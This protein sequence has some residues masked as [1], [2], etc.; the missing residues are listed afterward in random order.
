MDVSDAHV[1]FFSHRFFSAL[2]QQKSAQATAAATGE[3]PESIARTLGWQAPPTDPGELADQW[4]AEIDRAGVSRAAMI[5]SIPGDEESVQA[6][7]ARYPHRFFGYFMVNPT[8]S[9]AEDRVRKALEAGNLHAVCLFPAMHRISI[10]DERI[11]RI[12][13]VV[14]LFPRTLVFVHCGVLTVGVRR[15]LGLPS[16]FD[17]RFSD[18]ID[19]H[20]VALV[21][22]GIHFVVPHFGAGYFREALMLCDLCPNVYLD[23][24]SSNSWMRYQPERLDL[25][26]VFRRALDVAGPRRLLFGSDSSFFPRGWHKQVFAEQSQAL[27]SLDISNAD[28]RCIFG[29]N[30]E[31]LFLR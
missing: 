13:D 19:L 11:Q 15:K 28:A 20:R 1:H 6:A 27:A 14:S 22:P 18:P 16:P 8:A 29:E 10:Q 4:A 30:L 25:A 21:Y 12:L 5:A 31:N 9:G 26:E 23:T 2:A 24:S 17:M 3:T 7:V